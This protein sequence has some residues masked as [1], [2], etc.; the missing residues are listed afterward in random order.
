MWNGPTY[1]LPG[2]LR[3]RSAC[4]EIDQT[5]FDTQVRPCGRGSYAVRGPVTR[6]QRSG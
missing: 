5:E 1:G 6:P 2:Q 4:D 3:G